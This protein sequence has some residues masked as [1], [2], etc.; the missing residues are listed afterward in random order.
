MFWLW[1]IL[2]NKIFPGGLLFFLRKVWC[3]C[4]LRVVWKNVCFLKILC[5][6]SDNSAFYT[7]IAVLPLSAEK[8]ELEESNWFMLK[9][10]SEISLEGTKLGRIKLTNDERVE[11]G[12]GIPNTSETEP[13]TSTAA[14]IKEREMEE[15]S[16]IFMAAVYGVI[17]S[18]V[19]VVLVL[20]LI[21]LVSPWLCPEWLQTSK[22]FL[23]TNTM[24]LMTSAAKSVWRMGR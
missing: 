12:P 23:N 13:S 7:T 6:V 9:D 3:L 20:I 11:G 15:K 8:L 1:D 4:R 10:L 19:L 18:P 17:V 24:P 22:Y 21:F 5:T 2:E 14:E 16:F